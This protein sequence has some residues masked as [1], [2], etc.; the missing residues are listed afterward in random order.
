MRLPFVVL[1]AALTFA[2]GIAAAGES[3][4]RVE[5]FTVLTSAPENRN[6]EFAI[7]LPRNFS[8]S[9]ARILVTFGG[10][11]WGAKQTLDTY[12]FDD[13]ADEYGLVVVAPGFVNDDYWEPEKW[14]GAALEDALARIRKTH[15]IPDTPLLYY[16]YSA[17]GQCASLFYAWKP[18]KVAAWAAHAC[19]VWFDDIPDSIRLAPALVTCGVED[20]PRYDFGRHFAF[21]YREAGGELTWR[22][23]PGGHELIPEAAELARAFFAS[24]LE[25]GSP[26]ILVGDDGSGQVYTVDSR[27]AEHVPAELRSVFRTQAF[28]DLWQRQTR[29]K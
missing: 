1:L 19:G 27:Q 20:Q 17:G 16:G 7:R 23:Y 24:I 22:D 5:T 13:F 28:A 21:R 2:G 9:R 4:P 12:R 11:N 15:H 25:S 3:R 18:A 29:R 26:P 14:S 6:L 10:R 8:P